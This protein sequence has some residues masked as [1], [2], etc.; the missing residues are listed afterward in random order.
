M[1]SQRHTGIEAR[2]L[3]HEPSQLALGHSR[4]WTFSPLPRRSISLQIISNSG[5]DENVS[6]ISLAKT[7]QT[8]FELR[9]ERSMK[10]PIAFGCLQY[11]AGGVWI[12]FTLQRTFVSAVPLGP[13]D[14]VPL[15]E[16]RR[17]LGIE[18]NYT[19]RGVHPEVC[20]HMNQTECEQV[21]GLMRKL[22]DRLEPQGK[23]RALVLLVQA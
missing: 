5:K 21:D 10:S 13:E 16:Y 14:I 18:F 9:Q 1:L 15:A 2:P 7:T 22:Q 11:V 19:T 3:W 17:R 23:I 6:T 8:F 20:R 12:L 4:T